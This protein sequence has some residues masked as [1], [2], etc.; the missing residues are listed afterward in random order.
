MPFPHLTPTAINRVAELAFSYKRWTGRDLLPPELQGQA[1]AEAAW[2]APF[3]LLA[4]GV[5]ADPI[6]D[7]GNAQALALWETDW[8]GLTAT[9]SRQTAEP[10]LQEARARFMRQVTDFGFADDYSGIR[11]STQGR[12]FVIEGV[13][14][15]N[16]VDAGG[17]YLGQAA[18]IP[19]WRM[20]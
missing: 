2:S 15:W 1:L 9:P 8:T 10:D 11:L 20:L 19:R 13:T 7:Y 6:L 12:R 18:R 17:R 16:V 5:Q 3:A 14:V 4:H